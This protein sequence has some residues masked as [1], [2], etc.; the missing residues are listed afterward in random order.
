LGN[1]L[2]NQVLASVLNLLLT[3]LKPISHNLQ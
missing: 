1:R 3:L 2:A